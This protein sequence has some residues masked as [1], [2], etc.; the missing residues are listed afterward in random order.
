MP[1]RH[2]ALLGMPACL[3]RVPALESQLCSQLQLSA[4]ADPGRQQVTAQVLESLPSTSGT[5]TEFQYCYCWYL[6]SKPADGHT[7]SLVSAFQTN[8]NKFWGFSSCSTV[9]ATECVTPF[10]GNKEQEFHRIRGSQRC[11]YSRYL[12]PNCTVFYGKW[13]ACQL[14]PPHKTRHNLWVKQVCSRHSW[15]TYFKTG[16]HKT[17]H[18]E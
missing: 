3:I 8:K 16:F 4:N 7:P 15:S 11:V 18:E 14:P 12:F 13:K 17:S 1:G 10:L 2:L 6:G 5:Q 9:D